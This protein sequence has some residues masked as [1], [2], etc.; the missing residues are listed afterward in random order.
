MQDITPPHTSDT[1]PEATHTEDNTASPVVA[2]SYVSYDLFKQMDIRVG[3][4]RSIAPVAGAD[5]LLACQVDCGDTL[6]DGTPALR[7]IL[8]GIREYITDYESLI[9]KQVL[10]IVNL[11]PRMIRGMMSHGMLLAVGDGAPVFL[12]PEHS[13]PAGSKVR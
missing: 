2:P 4:I 12:V 1:S 3:T 11:E 5:K 10:Y 6:P 7:Q 9:D 8:S 13:V